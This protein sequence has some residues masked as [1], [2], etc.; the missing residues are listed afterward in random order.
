MSLQRYIRTS[1]RIDTTPSSGAFGFWQRNSTTLSPATSA[2]SLSIPGS[3]SSSEKFGASANASG[4]QAVAVGR[5]AQATLNGA[6]AVGYFA[7]ATKSATIAIGRQANAS[8]DY[9][10]AIGED[11]G[12]GGQSSI[13]IGVDSAVSSTGAT[14]LG[15]DAGA[16]A[17]YS[18]AIGYDPAV[19]ILHTNSIAIGKNATTTSANELTIGSANASDGIY[20]MR[21]PE[22]DII[23]KFPSANIIQIGSGDSLTPEDNAQSLGASLARWKAY[24]WGIS[25]GFGTSSH[26][27]PAYGGVNMSGTLNLHSSQISNDVSVSLSQTVLA[28]RQSFV[29]KW[30]SENFVGAVDTGIARSAAGVVGITNGSSGGGALRVGTATDATDA[31]DFVSGLT[32]NNRLFYDQSAGELQVANGTDD[33]FVRLRSASTTPI[34]IDDGTNTFLRY[35]KSA[36]LSSVILD[37]VDLGNNIGPSLQLW[38]NNNGA[39]PSAGVI[40][41]FDLNQTAYYLWV[42]ASGNLRFSTTAP[43]NANDTAG[44]LVAAAS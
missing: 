7:Q 24:S 44:T 21:F 19:H 18:V 36:T 10:I 29:I 34:S 35:G 6:V 27:E 31:G 1:S 23:F 30:S 43:I 8:A 3:G 16:G 41:L 37:P 38:N 28:V 40:V 39:T 22:R 5:S 32:A 2:D 14:A 25:V 26:G 20:S 42:D 4:S 11:A 15:Y 33:F 17:A 12:A 13:A 9:A